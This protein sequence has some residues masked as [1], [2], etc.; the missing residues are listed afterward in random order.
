MRRAFSFPSFIAASLLLS[1]PLAHAERKPVAFGLLGGMN[2][3]TLW[4]KDVHDVDVRFWPVAGFS[5]AFHLPEFLGLETDMLYASHGSAFKSDLSSDTTRVNTFNLQTLT[6]PLLL[7]VTA[8]IG[9]EVQPIFFGGP[10]LAYAF[11]KSGSSEKSYTGA[12]GL[13]QTDPINPALVPTGQMQDVDILLTLGGGLEWGLGSVQGRI[14]LG[15]RS[16]DSKQ[17][18]DVHTFTFDLMAGFIF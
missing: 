7:K 17:S 8:P 14:N 10:A 5:L 15:E 13:V 3:A 9:T 6:F 1:V 11:S 2:A 12:G 4:G 18:V 16:L